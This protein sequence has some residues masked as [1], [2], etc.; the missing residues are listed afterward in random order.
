MPNEPHQDPDRS[1]RADAER[2][3][4]RI[5][6]AA[7]HMYSTQGLQISMAAV[8]REAGVGKAT[9]SRRFG[10]RDELIAAVFAEHMADYVRAAEVAVADPDPWRG[11]TGFIETICEMQASDR[12]FADV[13]TVTIPHAEHLESLREA[14]YKK[15]V[16]LLEAARATGNL[17]E[18]FR[19][20][21]LV[22]F[23]MANAGV[24]NATATAATGSWR[25]LVGHLL[26]AISH[27]GAALP[28]M[29]AAPSSAELEQAMQRLS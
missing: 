18:D 17:R 10:S 29:P 12:G 15:F 2:N 19:S 14:S 3:R 27:P 24:V 21:D 1:L 13:L 16:A 22:L 9:L 20:E 25:R 6:I 4:D 5:L 26:R 7:R 28:P 23:L 8:A 11:F